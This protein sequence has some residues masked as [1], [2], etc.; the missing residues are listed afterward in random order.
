MSFSFS[1]SQSARSIS[2]QCW[3]PD[4]TIHPFLYPPAISPPRSL[5]FLLCISLTMLTF[6]LHNIITSAGLVTLFP[7]SCSC[8]PLRCPQWKL[9]MLPF[10]TP[11]TL[12]ERLPFPPSLLTL[13]VT[14]S[15]SSPSLNNLPRIGSYV[16]LCHL[17]VCHPSL[18]MCTFCDSWT[19]SI[20]AIPH[21]AKP[22]PVAVHNIPI[23]LF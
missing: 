20:L 5:T 22:P 7:T 4:E 3:F 1:S 12:M 10:H 8:S 16:L 14:F 21:T 9:C 19:F 2:L 23:L 13:A 6:F 17:N 15:S 11:N 18:P